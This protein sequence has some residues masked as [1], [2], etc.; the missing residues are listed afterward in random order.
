MLQSA[1]YRLGVALLL[2]GFDHAAGAQQC[3]QDLSRHDFLQGKSKKQGHR[4]SFRDDNFRGTSSSAAAKVPLFSSLFCD[5]GMDVT[6]L[7]TCLK[8]ELSRVMLDLSA[9]E[10]KKTEKD[11][12]DSSSSSS[13]RQRQP[14]ALVVGVEYGTEVIELAQAGFD[15][16]GIEPFPE[17]V[18]H[19]VSEAAKANVLDKVNIYSAGA[20]AALG[21][22][23]IT[24]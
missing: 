6:R 22:M 17:Y 21:N 12:R 19:V 10:E 20:G 23:S 11:K 24:Y 3:A 13:H 2:H 8:A 1:H 15:V 16:L 7:L 9:E 5:E 4:K 14:T 18:A